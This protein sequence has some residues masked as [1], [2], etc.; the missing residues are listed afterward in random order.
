MNLENINEDQALNSFLSASSFDAAS[1]QLVNRILES[2]KQ[3]KVQNTG[4]DFYQGMQE[5][6]ASL[7]IPRPVYMLACILVLGFVIGLND[8][9]DLSSNADSSTDTVNS[10]LYIEGEII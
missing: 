7:V 3:R 1:P 8:P 2:A 4:F 6:I 5:L 9:S 10:F